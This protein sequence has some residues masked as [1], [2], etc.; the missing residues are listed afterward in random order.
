MS[1]YTQADLDA[2][3]AAYASGVLQCEYAGKK[4]VFRS[5][6]EMVQIIE[7]VARE[8]GPSTAPS[9]VSVAEYNSR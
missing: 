1:A 9:R 5:A 6:A 7:A 4:T 3:R 8:V 2:L